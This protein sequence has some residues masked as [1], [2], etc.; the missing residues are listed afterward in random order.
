MTSVSRGAEPQALLPQ[1]LDPA[2]RADPY[3]VYKQFRDHGP[4]HLPEAN[5]SVFSAHRDCDEVLRHPSSSSDRLKSTVVQRLLAEGAPARPMGPP[6]FLF[7][8]PPDHTRLRKLVSK[9]FVPKVVNELQPDITEL[10]G[11]LFD[12]IAER[13]R[14]DVVSDLAYP[15]PVAVICRL[16]GVPLEDEPEFGRVSAMVAQA[17][18]LFAWLTGT[19]SDGFEERM[20]S[21]MWLRDYFHGLIER[22]RSDPGD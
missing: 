4:M 19:V 8:D 14:F 6:T 10:V 18:D 15:L 13:G 3:A 12:R 21:A 11:G 2:N 20:K 7:L 5:L 16:L 17:L 9:A 22:R 1:L